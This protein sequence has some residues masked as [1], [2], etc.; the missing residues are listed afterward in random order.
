[1]AALVS[2]GRKPIVIE[3]GSEPAKFWS[4]LQGDPSQVKEA[5]PTAPPMEKKL[6]H[7]Y[8]DAAGK[9]MVDE[10]EGFEQDD[11]N[12]DDVMIVDTGDEVYIWIGKDATREE[13][14]NSIQ[15]AARFVKTDMT[16]REDSTI[17][18]VGQGMEP[19]SFRSLFPSW[20][21]ALFEKQ[22]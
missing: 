21:E 11:L 6:I 16:I 22:R 18:R 4:S 14:E 10:V 5:E 12:E 9:F 13:K 2:P 15:V 7:C 8:V 17:I 20:D 3:Q 19:P 1:V